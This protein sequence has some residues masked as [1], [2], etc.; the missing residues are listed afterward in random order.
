LPSIR[1]SEPADRPRPRRRLGW[2]L[3]LAGV[4]TVGLIA[5]VLV[6]VLGDGSDSSGTTRPGS[7]SGVGG[8]VGSPAPDFRLPALDGHGDER[9]ADYR[10]RPVIVNFWASWCNPC[11][12]EFPLLKRALRRHR[13][14]HLAVIG[15]TYQDIPSD[16]R[17]FVEQRQATWPQG[18][19]EGGT[20]AS[21]YGVR[22]I[23][24]SF[25]VRADGTIAARVFGFTSEAALARPLAELLGRGPS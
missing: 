18:V 15:V 16:S 3:V 14:Q 24:Q 6:T 20:V 13:A 21:A 9:L 8:E 23:P 12:K 17:A 1:S 4:L 7:V 19:D 10:G 2:L 11:R 22:A 5:G 25:F